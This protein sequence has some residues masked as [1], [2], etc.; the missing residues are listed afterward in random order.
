MFISVK[1][2]TFGTQWQSLISTPM[3]VHMMVRGWWNHQRT[4]LMID[5]EE[6]WCNLALLAFL[7]YIILWSCCTFCLNCCQRL[8]LHLNNLFY[9]LRALSNQKIPCQALMKINKRTTTKIKKWKWFRWSPKS[10][11]LSSCQ[12]SP[13]EHFPFHSAIS[14]QC[15]LH[16][17]KHPCSQTKCWLQNW[18]CSN[19]HPGFLEEKVSYFV[20]YVGYSYYYLGFSHIFQVSFWITYLKIKKRKQLRRCYAV[21]SPLPTTT[22]IFDISQILYQKT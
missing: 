22:T 2:G 4:W 19:P 1:K 16:W 8:V 17:T 6:G 5:N 3:M 15:L 21:T 18:K 20:G 7:H 12:P 14:Y 10:Q 13:L 9:F 11:S